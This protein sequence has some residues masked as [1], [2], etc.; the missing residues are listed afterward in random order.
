MK[1]IVVSDTHGRSEVLTM[2]EKKHSDAT[3]FIH[4][5][6]VED[7]PIDFPKWYFVRGN[8]DFFGGFVEERIILAGDHRIYVCHSHRCPYYSRKETLLKEAFKRECDI[9]L[10]GHTHCS[11]IT[12]KNGILLVNPGSAWHTRDGNEPSYAILTL[13]G[14]SR[15]VELVFESEW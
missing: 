12:E 8:N 3:F 11:D 9:V 1:I 7:N 2:L 14:L 13:E 15:K 5:G 4:C 10:Y 6:D